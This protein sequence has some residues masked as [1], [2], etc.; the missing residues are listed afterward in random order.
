MLHGL[1]IGEDSGQRVVVA[2]GDGVEFVVVAAGAAQRL[3]EDAGADGV[4]HVVHNIHF[5]LFLDLLLKVGVSQN[6]VS[7]GDLVSRLFPG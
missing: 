3:T 4:E 1:H 6:Q 7:G 2:R 5:E